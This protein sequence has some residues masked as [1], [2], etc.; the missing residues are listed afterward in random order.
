MNR[1]LCGLLSVLWVGSVVTTSLTAQEKPSE[2]AA[3]NSNALGVRG[4]RTA[5]ERTPVSARGGL[6]QMFGYEESKIHKSEFK[7]RR[8]SIRRPRNWCTSKL[9]IRI[10][11]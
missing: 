2:K 5:G 1:R 9:A 4:F 10:T 3:S 7:G 6:I 11:R 8:A